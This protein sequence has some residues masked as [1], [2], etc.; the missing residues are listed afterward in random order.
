MN[1][2]DAPPPTGDSLPHLPPNTTSTNPAEA[3]PAPSTGSGSG[4]KGTATSAR[5]QAL[6]KALNAGALTKIEA[7]FDDETLIHDFKPHMLHK[8][9]EAF[10]SFSPSPAPPFVLADSVPSRSHR[11]RQP[12][13]SWFAGT[14]RSPLSS[15][16]RLARIAPLRREERFHVRP[17]SPLSFLLPS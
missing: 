12:T 8:Q 10:R 15:R 3:S 1:E 2:P 9:H 14:R 7:A 16:C 17:F 11:A 4:F 6:S 13:S 5:L